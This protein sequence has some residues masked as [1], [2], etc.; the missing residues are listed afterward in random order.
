MGKGRIATEAFARLLANPGEPISAQTG[1]AG[2]AGLISAI[3]RRCDRH[4]S[5]SPHCMHIEVEFP[6][7]RHVRV[8]A[9]DCTC[10]DVGN[11]CTAVQHLT[12]A[13]FLSKPA[14][15]PLSSQTRPPNESRCHSP[16][17]QE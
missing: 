13:V 10:T 15:P 14:E 2:A 16:L 11:S 12:K 6:T 3:S 7:A 5:T 1:V 4:T 8:S 9:Q 17:R